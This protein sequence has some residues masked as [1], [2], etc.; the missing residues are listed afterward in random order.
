VQAIP[1]QPLQPRS[2]TILATASFSI[3]WILA[4]SFGSRV[5]LNYETT[6]GR[7][8]SV[9]Q[10]WPDSRIQRAS[11]RATLVMLA[12]PHCPCTRAS[13][14]E[15]A[16]IMADAQG[17]VSAYVLFLKPEGS[18]AGWEKT[19][20]WRS[21]EAI[22][23]VTVLPDPHGAEARRFGVETS[24]HAVLFATDGRLLFSGGI[25]SSRGHSGDNAGRSAIASL[26]NNHTAERV[27]TSVFG[28]SLADSRQTADKR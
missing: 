21:A 28:C 3:V 13:V 27:R 6:P 12:H 25:T 10:S 1:Q 26:L 18:E 8:G 15:L 11:G 22:P 9:A 24:G 4:V 17:R 2:K 14:G 5:L 19:D 16:Q 23:G 7:V 20:L